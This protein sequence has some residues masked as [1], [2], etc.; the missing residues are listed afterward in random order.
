MACLAAI[1]EKEIAFTKVRSP[2]LLQRMLARFVHRTWNFA[3]SGLGRSASAERAEQK[4]RAAEGCFM[5]QTVPFDFFIGAK[6]VEGER[7]F[8]ATFLVARWKA[9]EPIWAVCPLSSS[10]DLCQVHTLQKTIQNLI[11]DGMHNKQARRTNTR[12]N[13]ELGSPRYIN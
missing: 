12:E 2:F 9:G 6:K 5:A 7:N 10:P 11:R 4:E 3:G 13:D 8:K 1:D